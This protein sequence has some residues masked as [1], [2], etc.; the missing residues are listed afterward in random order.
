MKAAKKILL[1]VGCVALLGVSWLM[2]VSAKT[3]A[4]T[5]RELI[6]EANAY[7]ADEI[8][9]RA[10]PLLEEASSY[11]DEYTA[12]AEALLKDAYLKLLDQSDYR[13]GYETLLAKQMARS[14][15]GSDVFLEAAEYYLRVNE[16]DSALAVM[17][18][19]IARTGDEKL[20]ELY[21]ANRYAFTLRDRDYEDVT[22]ILNGAIAVKRD[23]KWGIANAGGDLV[24]PCEYD[25]VSSYCNGAVVVMKDGVTYAVNTDNNRIALYHGTATDIGN[26][27]QN[28]LGLKTAE[29]WV[30]ANSGLYTAA[31]V[32]DEMG[33]ASGGCVPARVGDKWGLLSAAGEG[34]LTQPAYDDIIR[35]GLGRCYAQGALFLKSGGKL[36]LAVGGQWV[37]DE[38]E[39]A[40]PFADG[41]AAVKKNGKWGFINTAGEVM[42]DYRFE[43]ALSFGQHLAAVKVD[44]LWGYVSLRGELVIEPQFLDA[45]SFSGGYAPVLTD[46]G[47]GFI[48]LAEYN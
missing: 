31:P 41:W 24:I 38:Y 26:M 23:G 22:A 28:V 10:I 37:G 36:R 12:Q 42:I 4:D 32:V 5:Q 15:A 39:D 46:T 20:T 8:Y 19:G 48:S 40:R 17:R 25:K 45:R 2:A 13:D 35:D 33:A 1:L 43:D 7:L 14:A 29:G 47:W 6:N 21:E 30:L 27:D 44:G 9:V 18:D 34:W 3:D 11:E 16:Y